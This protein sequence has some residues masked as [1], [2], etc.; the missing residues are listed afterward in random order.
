MSPTTKAVIIE[1]I[2]NQTIDECSKIAERLN[3]PEYPQSWQA[4]AIAI[5]ALILELKS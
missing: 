3:K 2:R 4:C 1:D 5:K